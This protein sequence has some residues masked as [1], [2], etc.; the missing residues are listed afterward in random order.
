MLTM[1]ADRWIVLL[2]LCFIFVSSNETDFKN[3]TEPNSDVCEM[4]TVSAQLGSSVL[5]PCN[6]DTSSM[7]WVT[8]ANT[9]GLDLVHLTSEGR[10]RFLDHRYGRVKAFPNQGSEGNYSILIDELQNSDLGSYRCKHGRECLQ[11]ELVAEKANRAGAMSEEVLLVIYICVGVIAFIL[12]SIGGYCCMKCILCCY[13]KTMGNTYNVE[14]E[15]T[16]GAS[17]PPEETGRGPVDHQQRG[18]GN[19]NLVYENDDQDP[20]NQEDDLSRNYCNPVGDLPDPTRSQPTQSTSGMYPNLNEFK[21]MDSQRAKQG[22]HI[23]LFSRLRQASVGRHFYVNQ[24]EINNQQAMATQAENQ[25]KA[26][27]LGKK[28][29]AKKNGEFKNPIYNRST[30]QLNNL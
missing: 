17:A 23:E 12:L 26:A 30:D 19:D 11:V 27:G 2:A 21:R 10:I 9:T 22:F 8:W 29:R 4:Q 28:K 1:N 16:A 15:G 3:Y 18:G 20:S 14:R 24:G 13:N 25:H 5:L 7:N 6:F